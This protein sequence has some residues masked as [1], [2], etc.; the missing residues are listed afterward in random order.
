MNEFFNA[1]T[2][3][4]L[5]DEKPAVI[6]IIGCGGKT[7]FI[8]SLAYECRHKKV[9]VTPT[10]KILPMYRD[11][12]VLCTSFEECLSHKAVNGIQCLGVMNETT[13]KLEALREEMLEKIIPQYDLVLL[14]ADGSCGLSCKG[15][16]PNEPVIPWFSTHT[17]GIVT[18]YAL[19]KPADSDIVLRLKEFLKLTGLEQGEPI[20]QKA[21]ADMVCGTNGMFHNGAGRQSIFVNQV[22]DDAIAALAEKWLKGIEESFPGRFACLA[23]GSARKNKWAALQKVL[24]CRQRA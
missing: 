8:E 14:E 2:L 23:Y 4:D 1:G 5:E 19:G 10:T 22:E 13:G 12:I 9:L 18:F 21:L 17:I 15:W 20:T 6:A 7:T 3:L 11:D 16:L 24:P